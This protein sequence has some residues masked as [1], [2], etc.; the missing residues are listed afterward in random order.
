MAGSG[1]ARQGLRERETE[2][3]DLEEQLKAA[4][5]GSGNFCAVVGPAGIGKSSL[6]AA[7]EEAARQLGMQM[8]RARASE[9][10]RSFGFGL[11]RQLF[12]STVR[13]ADPERRQAMGRGAAGRA[14]DLI[15]GR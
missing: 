6:L 12:E 4:V 10:E 7:T 15:S 2:L 11:V 3:A 1:R 9:L 8:C 5:G 13:T 14:A